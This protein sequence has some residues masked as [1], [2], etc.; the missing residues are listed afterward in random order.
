MCAPH[1]WGQQ[2]CV[3]HI[4]SSWFLHTVQSEFLAKLSLCLILITLQVTFQYTKNEEEIWT[5]N[6][7]IKILNLANC[8]QSH[9]KVFT[10][11]AIAIQRFAVT[12]MSNRPTYS[13][14]NECVFT[15]LSCQRYHNSAIKIDIVSNRAHEGEIDI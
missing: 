1:C 14:M 4:I 8:T 2:I 5:P 9:K 12:K 15:A 6:K 13:C 3:H 10:N 11:G 7:N